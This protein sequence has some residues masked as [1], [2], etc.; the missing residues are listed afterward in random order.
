MLTTFLRSALVLAL[1]KYFIITVY[2]RSRYQIK[3][4]LYISFKYTKPK[5]I[6]V[7]I[8]KKQQQKYT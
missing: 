5:V 3:I 1:K 7:Q 4:N 2:L 8:E 6:N